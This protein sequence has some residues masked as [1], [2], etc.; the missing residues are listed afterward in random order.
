MVSN[1][2]KVHDCILEGAGVQGAKV[3]HTGKNTLNK[4][5][6]TE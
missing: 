6:Q 4:E 3:L 2:G 5:P 1:Q